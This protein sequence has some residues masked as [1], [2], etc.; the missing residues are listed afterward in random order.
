MKT[1]RIMVVALAIIS[2]SVGVC[3]ALGDNT[4]QQQQGQVGINKNKN[5]N[6]NN[7]DS[8]ASSRSYASAN[9]RNSNSQNQGQLQG[10]LQGQMQ[11]QIA[12]QGNSQSTSFSENHKQGEALYMGAPPLN[13][14]KGT[15]PAQ[16]YSLLGGIGTQETER[17]SVLTERVDLIVLMQKNGYLTP[18]EAKAEAMATLAELKEITK[19]KRLLGIL[20]KTE[21][22]HLL[23]G[24]G[25]L[26]WD[27]AYDKGPFEGKL[28]PSS[29]N[30]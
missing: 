6:I 26:S 1:L 4:N 10:Q 28:I 18:E 19:S 14:P 11:G 25:L 24:L 5:T 23:N 17:Y 16:I 27:S 22:R 21:G 9:N 8:N 2:L 12:S 15:S 30:K 29:D 13:A 3:L 20:W 7:N